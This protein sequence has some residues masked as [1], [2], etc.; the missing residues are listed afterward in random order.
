[1]SVNTKKTKNLSQNNLTAIFSL[2]FSAGHYTACCRNLCS[3]KVYLKNRYFTQENGKR[4]RGDIS[5]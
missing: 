5:N 3:D 4:E 2:F 1:M